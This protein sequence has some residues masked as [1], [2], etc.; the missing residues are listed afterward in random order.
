MTLSHMSVL[1]PNVYVYIVDNVKYYCLL[2]HTT[3]PGLRTGRY[4]LSIDVYLTLFS[5]KGFF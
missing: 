2:K 4:R 3:R 5:K 1:S